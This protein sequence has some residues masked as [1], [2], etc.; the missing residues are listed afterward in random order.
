MPYML[1]IVMT[2]NC[3]IE[4]KQ[5]QTHTHTQ[6]RQYTQKHINIMLIDM[7]DKPHFLSESDLNEM[8]V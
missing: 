8:A 3:I 5:N 1:K 7:V 4:S 2:E 6:T